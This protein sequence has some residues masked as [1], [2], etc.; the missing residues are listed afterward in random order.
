MCN[1][2]QI[3]IYEYGDVIVCS[4]N[5][6]IFIGEDAIYDIALI[7]KIIGSSEGILPLTS[8][9]HVYDR[10]NVDCDIVCVYDVN[11]WQR[12]YDNNLLDKSFD[13][14]KWLIKQKRDVPKEVLDFVYEHSQS[15][16]TNLLMNV[17]NSSS[18]KWLHDNGATLEPKGYKYTVKEWWSMWGKDKFCECL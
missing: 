11:A 6:R 13:A 5:E 10:R 16:V 17:N 4:N 1:Y 3:G 8:D 12:I 7:R 15:D 14:I 18:V 2:S 9:F